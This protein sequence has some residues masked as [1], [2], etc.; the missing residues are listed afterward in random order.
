MPLPGGPSDKAGN[1]YEARWT[2]VQMAYVLKGQYDSIRLEPPGSDGKGVEFWLSRGGSREFHQVK[3][4]GARRGHW[5]LSELRTVLKSFRDHLIAEETECVFVSS[6]DAYELRELA[7][8]ARSADR[9]EEFIQ[10]FAAGEWGA[11]FQTILQIWQDCT[12]EQAYLL[13]RKIR[14]DVIGEKLLQRLM[15]AELAPLVEK[16]ASAACDTLFK[17]SFDSVHKELT[18]KQINSF[19]EQ[20]GY[21]RPIW[22]QPDTLLCTVQDANERFVRR[23]K[24]ELISGDIIEREEGS[25][26]LNLLR[27]SSEKRGVFITGVA[28]VG[29]ST[30]LLQLLHRLMRESVPVL[31]FRID[32]LTPTTSPD[33]AGRQAMLPASPAKTLAAFAQGKPSVLIIDQLDAVSFASG[34]NP[35]FF[36]CFEELIQ[37]ALALPTI[38]VV[39]ACRRFDFD[40]DHRFRRLGGERNGL[41]EHV[42][43]NPLSVDM[44]STTLKKMG[45]DPSPFTKKQ[46]RLLSIPAHLKLMGELAEDVSVTLNFDTANQLYDL[47]WTRKDQLLRCLL[48]PT[49]NWSKIVDRICAEMSE[50]ELLTVAESS[51]DD[52]AAIR[53]ALLSENI[54]VRDGKR[55]SFFHEGFFDYAFARNFAAR[56]GDLVGMLLSAE[57]HLFRR[58]QVRQILLHQRDIDHSTYL[59]TLSTLLESSEIRYH[60]KQVVLGLVE[61]FTD[62]SVDEW[63]VLASQLNDPACSYR[64]HIWH[65]IRTL[66]WFELLNS[67]NV[68]ATWLCNDDPD[69][70]DQAMLLIWRVQRD[71]ADRVACLL[72]E[73]VD[74]SEEWS[75]RLVNL[76]KYGSLDAGRHYF[77][78][79]MRLL[80]AGAFDDLIAD[81]AD[82]FLTILHGL[83]ESQPGWAC[84]VIGGYLTRLIT[85]SKKEGKTNPFDDN[86]PIYSQISDRVFLGAARS[87][88]KAY[89]EHVLPVVLELIEANADYGGEKPF[90]DGV[91]RWRYRDPGREVGRHVFH[92]TIEGLRSLARD[93]P[94]LFKQTY[95]R[96]KILTFETVEFMLLRALVTNGEAFSDLAIDH[97]CESPQ[98][99]NLDYNIDGTPREIACELIKE[100]TRHCSKDRL[101]KLEDI[102]LNYYP[103]WETTPSGIKFRGE[104]Q[105]QVLCAIDTSKRSARLNARI[106]EW[107][108]KFGQAPVKPQPRIE[109]GW[110]GSP[111]SVDA[112]VKMTDDHW[113]SAIRKY[114]GEEQHRRDG[115]LVGG[116]RQ[117]CGVLEEQVKVDQPRFARLLLRFPDIA[118]R[119]Y[120]E[121]VLRGLQHG[122]AGQDD[123]FS[124]CRRCHELP[125]RPVGSA[126]CFL[127][128]RQSGLPW[129]DDLLDAISWYATEDADPTRESWRTET[130]NG[131]FYYGG[132]IYAAGINSVRGAAAGAMAALMFSDQSRISHFEPAL[133]KMV[134]DPSISVRSC[135]AL[136]L[137][138]ILNEKPE[139]ALCLFSKLCSTEDVLLR[140]R[141][142][143]EFLMYATFS[144]FLAIHPV[145]ERMIAS[146]DPDVV[147]AGARRACN[148][149]LVADKG[150]MKAKALAAKCTEGSAPLRM[151][152][153]E[154]YSSSI[155]EQ[156]FRDV[157]AKLLIP[158]FSDSSKEV[159][160]RAS[161]CF[162]HIKDEGLAELNRLV[163]RFV[164][165]TSFSEEYDQLIWALENS[166]AKL[167]DLTIAVCDRFLS[168]A[169]EDAAN[170]QSRAAAFSHQLGPLILRAYHQASGGSVRRRCLDTMDRLLQAG[171]YGI[172][173][174]ITSF[175]R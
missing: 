93:Y 169:E 9:H 52:H 75:A 27:T 159:R 91:W 136:T 163:D 132:D 90:V 72:E 174:A 116:A 96:L 125:S 56:G 38:R 164:E 128:E 88:P 156:R 7:N 48:G 76:F 170:V 21:R 103:Q 134:I 122:G 108:R 130:S 30:F 17:W 135:V 22:S 166:T 20:S 152:A 6:Q 68:I 5:L 124:A 12:H 45:V 173:D 102:L 50:R 29:K 121:A 107:N 26:I 151:G 110:I 31:S 1:S 35:Q 171:A 98:R 160:A 158:F 143:E 140:T 16:R 32:N 49:S 62:P 71:A 83:Q 61:Q 94:E 131:R 117:L 162:R 2:V 4:Q 74:V 40:N 25:Q 138:Y 150:A 42:A 87:A 23:L 41:F 101:A 149:S 127:M 34:R 148:A 63:E 69:T 145:I 126:L 167:P 18:A 118:N 58:S 82:N 39:I 51:L 77:D 36:E 104:A 144:H 92:A 15:Q 106:G 123:I 155:G 119:A 14:V 11:H 65:S 44:V 157:S 146:D 109:M 57:Q 81:S 53:D 111:I 73:Y 55:I 114:T 97:L 3:L 33:E 161:N 153:A 67:Q 80:N 78:L 137:T 43:I 120:Y 64:R 172:Q 95:N 54:L 59:K 24:N 175:D 99:L 115:S 60:L 70:V 100:V 84:E 89:L 112:A 147:Q 113:L 79:F 85:L 141:R 139:L 142:V 13:L 165:S 8:R 47:F 10:E 168:F 37:Q 154:I 46:L 19:L 86:T 28:G 66:P 133:H 129:P 105:L